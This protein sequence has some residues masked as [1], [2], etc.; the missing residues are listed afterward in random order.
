MLRRGTGVL[1]FSRPR[2]VMKYRRMMRDGAS[3]AEA[4]AEGGAS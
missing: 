4:V 2:L 1:G 3:F